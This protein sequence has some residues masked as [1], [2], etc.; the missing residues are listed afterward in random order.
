LC[1]EYEP[2]AECEANIKK[3]AGKDRKDAPKTDDGEN[4]SAVYLLSMLTAAMLML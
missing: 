1:G 3:Y 4:G 2:E